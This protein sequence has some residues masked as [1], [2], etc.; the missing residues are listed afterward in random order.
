MLRNVE[1][2]CKPT[3][4]HKQIVANVVHVSWIHGVQTFKVSG[5]ILISLWSSLAA[6]PFNLHTVKPTILRVEL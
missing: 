6:T 3:E 4:G 5:I 2:H 1:S